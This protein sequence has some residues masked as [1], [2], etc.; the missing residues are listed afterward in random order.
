MVGEAGDGRAGDKSY[1]YIPT[2]LCRYL[3]IGARDDQDTQDY[4]CDDAVSCLDQVFVQRDIA[5]RKPALRVGKWDAV[6]ELS[7]I[8]G[9]CVYAAFNVENDEMVRGRIHA[10]GQDS[11]VRAGYWRRIVEGFKRQ[12]GLRDEICSPGSYPLLGD[13]CPAC[14]TNFSRRS[15]T[16]YPGPAYLQ[17]QIFHLILVCK[18]GDNSKLLDDRATDT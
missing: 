18:R 2:A 3:G 10:G 11:L 4:G 17:K 5:R 13:Y 1:K 15:N 16:Q 9:M 14:R 12:N 6:A 8:S 7:L